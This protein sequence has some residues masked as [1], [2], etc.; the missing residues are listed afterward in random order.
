MHVNP[1]KISGST[2]THKIYADGT[3]IT[4][5]VRVVCESKK[6]TRLAD[7]RITDQKEFEKHNYV[8]GFFDYCVAQ[9]I[10]DDEKV[11]RATNS[12]ATEYV[13]TT[14]LTTS[15]SKWGGNPVIRSARSL[16]GNR[17]H[18][19]RLGGKRFMPTDT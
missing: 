6:Q 13:L 15:K 19:W 1:T 4:L 7:A 14:R 9:E 2:D 5:R 16:Y 12:K 8:N 17:K 18:K 3:D 11:N 10:R